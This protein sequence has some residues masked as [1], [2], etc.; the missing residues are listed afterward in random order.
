METEIEDKKEKKEEQEW[1]T[2]RG[3]FKGKKGRFEG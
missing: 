1:R 3:K 2:R